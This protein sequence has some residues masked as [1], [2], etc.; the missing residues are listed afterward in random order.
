M[1][2]LGAAYVLLVVLGTVLPTPQLW[3]VHV[4]AFLSPLARAAVLALLASGVAGLAF[5]SAKAPGRS[6]PSGRRS[7]RR[8]E[9]RGIGR[10]TLLL[11]IPAAAALWL[12][13]AQSFLLGDQALLIDRLQ[14][15]KTELHSEPLSSWIWLAYGRFLQALSLP[16]EPPALAILPVLCGV[17]AILLCLAI[18]LELS[19]DRPTQRFSAAVL[20]LCGISQLYFGYI[21]SYPIAAVAI[22][23]FL[24]LGLRWIH[25]RGPLLAPAIALPLSI[26]SHLASAFLVPAYL[27]L[28]V[29]NSVHPLRRAAWAMA[30]FLAVAGVFTLLGLKAQD[31]AR[32]IALLESA[33]RVMLGARAPGPSGLLLLPRVALDLANLV[34]LVAAVPALLLLWRLALWRRFPLRLEYDLAFLGLA[35]LGGGLVACALTLPGSPAQDWDL[36]GVCLLPASVFAVAAAR[37]V[38][39]TAIPRAARR[40]LVLLGA[41]SLLSFVLLNADA[42]AGLRRFETLMRDDARLSPHERAYGSEKLGDYFLTQGDLPRA[43][44]YG[45]LA[46][47]ADSAD[48]RYWGKVGK[49]LYE[50]GRYREA[51]EHFSVSVDRGGA[52]G[53]AFYYIGYCRFYLG[54]PAAAIP[55][56]GRAVRLDPDEPNYRGALGLALIQSGNVEQG[57]AVWEELLRRWPDHAQTRTAYRMMFGTVPEEGE[58][59]RPR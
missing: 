40:G 54:E 14:H 22:L 7:P 47:R 10:W 33:A 49:I 42:A 2:A 46:I 41:G 4:P 20:L 36:V 17:L 34:L 19:P 13:R 26:A 12:L 53:P 18:G 15:G 8:G 9:S 3:G 25:R 30:P 23:F 52:I 43:L 44:H 56:F 48:W 24:W 35:A 45:R 32:P 37:D 31:I 27:L 29:R 6:R 59:T 58:I 57:R 11:L 38:G 39:V 1:L 16:V 55:D 50:L 28:S 51:L 5:A 21:E